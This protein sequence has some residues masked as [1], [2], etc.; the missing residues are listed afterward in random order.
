MISA[1]EICDLKGSSIQKTCTFIFLFFIF[2]GNVFGQDPSFKFLDDF[3]LGSGGYRSEGEIVISIDT[4]SQGNIYVLTYGDGVYKF[5]PIN[6]NYSKIINDQLGEAGALNAPLDIAIDNNDIIHIADG[7]SK[8]IKKFDTS[9]NSKGNIGVGAVGGGKDEFWQPTGLEFDSENNLYIVDADRRDENNILSYLKIYYANGT[10]KSFQGPPEQKI[11]NPYRVAANNNYILISHAANNGEVLVLNKDLS[12][13]SKLNSIGSPGSLYIDKSDFIYAID[14][15]EE[16]DFTQVLKLFSGNILAALQLYPKIVDGISRGEFKMQ[17]YNSNLSHYLTFNDEPANPRSQ[18]G[19]HIQFPL[20]I[21]LDGSCGKLFLNDGKVNGLELDF[22]LEIY[23]RTP[24]FDVTKPTAQCVG[25]FELPLVDGSASITVDDINDASTDNCGIESI[26]LSQTTFTEADVYDVVMTVTDNA[27]N[28]DT[29]TLEVTVTDD[30]TPLTITN[31]DASIVN[32]S[33]DSNCEYELE[34][35]RDDF[36]TS[37]PEATIKQDPLPGTTISDDQIITLTPVLDGEEGESCK[38]TVSPSDATK[39]VITN[40]PEDTTVSLKEG[41]TYPVPNYESEVAFSDN[42]DTNLAFSQTPVAGTEIE[43]TTTVTITVTDNAG[44]K[45]TCSFDIIVEKV[46]E[47]RIQCV[48]NYTAELGYNSNTVQILTAELVVGDTSGIEF[49][50]ETQQFSC[51]DI[52][53]N[54]VIIKASNS[55]TGETATCTVSVT[56]IDVGK[57]LIVCPA[58]VQTR[59]IPSSG[60]FILPQVVDQNG[61]ADNCSPYEDLEVVQDPSAGTEFTGE[62]DYDII[63]T[64]TDPYNN[65][66][67]CEVTYRLMKSSDNEP[68]VI[69]CPEDISVNNDNGVCGAVINFDDPIATD[70]SDGDISI[71]RSD[72]IDL[73]SGDVFPVGEYTLSYIA[74]DSSGNSSECSFNIKISDTQP[75]V[76]ECKP[77]YTFTFQSGTT[78]ILEAEDLLNS[79]RDNCDGLDIVLNLDRTDFTGEDD[80]QTI[81]VTLTASDS[82]NNVSTCT[83]PVEIRVIEENELELTCIDEYIIEADENCVYRV[84]DFSDI[85]DTSI[86]G[87]EI[88]QSLEANSV[89]DS[90]VDPYIRVTATFEDQTDF[91]DIYLIPVDDINPVI[92]CPEDEMINISSGETYTMQDYTNTVGVTD[93]CGGV[94][95]LQQPEPGTV[96]DEDTNILLTATDDS[97]NTTKCEF[98]IDLLT[99]GE[100]GIN[101]PSNKTLEWDENCSFILPDYTEEANVINGE[102][103]EVSQNPLPGTLI[104]NAQVEVTLNVEV[105]QSSVSCSFMINLEDNTPPVLQ[106]KDININLD[107]QGTASVSFEDIDNGSYDNCDPDVTYTLSKSVFSCKE[108]GVNQVQVLAEDS[109]GNSSTATTTITVNDENA[110]CNDPL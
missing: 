40:C 110:V 109:Q 63:L 61:I 24:S 54:S 44:L 4:D 107:E 13:N 90:N 3:N 68:P 55:D 64:V 84:P 78:G 82:N 29:C 52:G 101:C 58:D 41:E 60:V 102:G 1:A 70:N 65:V 92:V 50:I 39:P 106:L 30:E 47:F 34:D 51:D 94:N 43:E 48:E 96:I 5:N 37:D 19:D 74:S 87:A 95:V 36:T 46:E 9:G 32:V 105:E 6:Q 28:K 2:S 23:Q 11:E 77:T 14:Y 72:T 108:L 98:R 93:N 99:D 57:P 62:G 75:P 85:V 38:F 10:F 91:C 66:A 104:T 45:D 17:I 35:Y 22:N 16:I 31:C 73:E 67:V 76:I 88:Q 83:V 71:V 53:E 69:K 21:A 80:G 56:V 89:F 20:D 86:D 7:G 8:L 97:G 27:G 15:G 79:Y 59:E 49:D 25:N 18:N 81:N 26:T 100:V 42:C 103:L 33:F 12:Y